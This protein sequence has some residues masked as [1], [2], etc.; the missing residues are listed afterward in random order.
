MYINYLECFITLWGGGNML[1]AYHKPIKFEH[2]RFCHLELILLIILF[3]GGMFSQIISS[4]IKILY[5][6]SFGLSFRKRI[7]VRVGQIHIV[8]S[9]WGNRLV[10]VIA[11]IVFPWLGISRISICA[12]FLFHIFYPMP[13]WSLSWILVIY[14]TGNNSNKSRVFASWYACMW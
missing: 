2:M 11:I 5:C 9:Y 10:Q 4:F 3:L 13:L 8:I 14:A 7:L 1:C 12:W 6:L